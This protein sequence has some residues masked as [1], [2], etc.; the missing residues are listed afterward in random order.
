[1]DRESL[2]PQQ[3]FEMDHLGCRGTGRPGSRSPSPASTLTMV[4]SSS[5]MMSLSGSKTEISN[6]PGHAPIRRT[7]RPP[8][9]RRTTTSSESTPSTG[10][11]TPPSSSCCSTSVAAGV[12]TPELLHPDTQ[13]RRLDHH[14]RRSPGARLR[15]PTTPWQRVL[16]AGILTDDQI[17]NTTLRTRN[18][19]PAD[20][21]HIQTELTATAWAKTETLA[22]NRSLDLDTLRTNITN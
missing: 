5:I 13:T 11:T 9:S 6:R 7:T 16:D 15:Q 21:T 12:A 17:A 10:D 14:N 22:A 19:N 18:V 3:R 4:Q 8:L 1:M 2:D 20:L